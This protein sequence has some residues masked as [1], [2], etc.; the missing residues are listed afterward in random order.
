MSENKK[1]MDED[2]Y[3]DLIDAEHDREEMRMEYDAYQ[4]GIY[5][6]YAMHQILK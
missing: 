4:A 2:I 1:W 3:N 6:A 5:F